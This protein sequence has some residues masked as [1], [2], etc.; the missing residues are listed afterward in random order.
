[1][2]GGGTFHI[3]ALICFFLL[4]GRGWEAGGGGIN[5]SRVYKPVKTTTNANNTKPC[6][7]ASLARYAALPLDLRTGPLGGGVGW[8]R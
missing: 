1:V 6:P 3:A 8:R 2:E 4:A 7:S 5:F